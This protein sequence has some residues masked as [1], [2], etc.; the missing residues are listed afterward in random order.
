MAGTTKNLIVLQ[1]VNP[2]A[3]SSIIIIKGKK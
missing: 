3:V 2:N 1:I